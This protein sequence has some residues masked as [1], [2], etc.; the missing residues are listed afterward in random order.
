MGA[1]QLVRI[2]QALELAC[3][4]GREA[5]VNASVPQLLQAAGPVIVFVEDFCKDVVANS[6]NKTV[7]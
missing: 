2:C 6:A 7:A 3:H 5:D 4:E 1:T